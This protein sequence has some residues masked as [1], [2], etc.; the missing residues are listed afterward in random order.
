MRGYFDMKNW[1]GAMK[2][3]SQMNELLFSNGT[4]HRS[5]D[6]LNFTQEKTILAIYDNPCSSQ[7]DLSLYMGLNKGAISKIVQSLVELDLIKRVNKEGDRRT[8]L[9]DLTD[10]GY[11]EAKRIEYNFSTHIEKVISVLS[12][13]KQNEL[14]FHLNKILELAEEIKEKENV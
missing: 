2:A 11:K 13:T 8:I 4:P 1:T 6:C 5:S 10:Q 12:E 14:Y 9:L 7:K 3:I